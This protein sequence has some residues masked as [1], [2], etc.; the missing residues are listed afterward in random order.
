[1]AQ[2]W[3]TPELAKALVAAM[4]GG[5]AKLSC[6]LDLGLST[7]HVRLSPKT[8]T[9]AEGVALSFEQLR[10]MASAKRGVFVFEDGRLSPVQISADYFYKLIPTDEAPTIEISGIQMH[11]TTGTAPFLNAMNSAKTVVR[12]GAAV[13]DTCGGLG[14]TAIAAARLGAASVVSLDVDPNVREIAHMNPWSAEYFSSPV[15]ELVDA[16]AAEFVAAQ[17]DGSFDCVVHDPPRFSR[18]GHLYGEEFYRG[19]ARV[20]RPRGR[21][22]HYTGDP[23]SKSRGKSFVQGVIRR[24]QSAGFEPKRAGHLQGVVA[25]RD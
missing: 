17:P 18:A 13:L 6:S 22:F 23:F 20:L 5:Q 24:L 3:L 21:L 8:V 14:Y 11:R 25:R 19:L 16:D 12:K 15:I 4:H 10:E 2:Y 7:Q 9:L 1:M